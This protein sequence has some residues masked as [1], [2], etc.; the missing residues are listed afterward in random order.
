[1]ATVQKYITK[2]GD[3]SYR[4]RVRVSGCPSKSA[5]FKKIA[6]ARLWLSKTEGDLKLNKHLPEILASR[7]TVSDLLSRYEAEVEASHQNKDSYLVQKKQQ[8]SFWNEKIGAKTLIELTPELFE[9]LKLELLKSGLKGKRSNA[10]VN[11]YF[12]VIRHAL[13][14]GERWGWVIKNPI[15]NVKWLKEPLGRVRFLYPNELESLLKACRD[16][17]SN[18][19]LYIIVLI[20][21]ST[22]A[23]RNEIMKLKK[24]DVDFER[25]AAVVYDTKNGLPRKLYIND[26]ICTLIKT[27]IEQPAIRIKHSD[28]VFPGPSGKQPVFIEKEWQAAKDAAG[29]KN[30]RFHDLRHTAAS[31]IAMTGGTQSDIKD[32][33]GHKSIKMTERYTHLLDSHIKQVIIKMNDNM[34]SKLSKV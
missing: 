7:Y 9:S 5:T 33:L 25:C 32:V 26:N 29:V 30:F 11:R 31:Y 17:K 27:W 6:E 1:M 3:V 24:R 22:G 23:R 12:A 16:I 15:A 4:A 14:R 8:I 2:R 10:T 13:N 28:Y 21:L 34:F 20:A 18:K 19:P